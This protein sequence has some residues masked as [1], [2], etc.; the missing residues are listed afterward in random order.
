MPRLRMDSQLGGTLHTARRIDDDQTI[1][2]C[3]FRRHDLGAGGANFLAA[4]IQAASGRDPAA[5]AHP[6]MGGRAPD[7]APT[8]VFSVLTRF[9]G[10]TGHGV[11]A[12]AASMGFRQRL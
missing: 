2:N 4:R 6:I 3:M 11:T 12:P 9:I 8:S 5:A 7:T 1:C 10:V